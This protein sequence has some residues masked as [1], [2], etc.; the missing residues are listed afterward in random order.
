[1]SLTSKQVMSLNA[2][3]K[4]LSDST[5]NEQ[6]PKLSSTDITTRFPI[7]LYKV[8]AYFT[9][10]ELIDVIN[11]P[12]LLEG[13]TAQPNVT[14]L[15]E[16]LNPSTAKATIARSIRAHN[17]IIQSLEDA[18][19]NLII[20][21][22][23]GHAYEALKRLT[24][25]YGLTNSTTHA[26]TLIERLQNITKQ[27]SESMTE[28][29]TR[30]ERM[31]NDIQAVDPSSAPNIWYKSIV[32]KGLRHL[33]DY[34]SISLVVTQLD[35]NN[36]WTREAFH[37]YLITQDERNKYLNNASSSSSSSS[38]S[39][40]SSDND[41][42]PAKSLS[43]HTNNNTNNKKYHHPS[44]KYKHRNNNHRNNQSSNNRSSQSSSSSSSRPK[45]CSY[46]HKDGHWV[47]ECRQN[48]H[49]DD[50]CYKCHRQGHRQVDCRSGKRQRDN[51]SNSKS[52][53]THQDNNSNNKR[54]KIDDT[55][56]GYTSFV[57]MSYTRSSS[58]SRSSAYRAS[59]STSSSTWIA[60]SAATHHFTGNI[61]LL[62]NITKLSKPRTTDTANGIATCN[63]IGDIHLI[64]NN[65]RLTLR[66]VMYIPSF[67]VNLISVR[68]LT[69]TN[70]EF[71]A[72]STHA[73][74]TKDNKTL[75]TFHLIDNLYQVNATL[76]TSS[77]RH[78]PIHRAAT[79]PPSEEISETYTTVYGSDSMNVEGSTSTISTTPSSSSSSSN[80]PVIQLPNNVKVIADQI[81]DLHIRHGHINY[82]RLMKMIQEQYNH[83]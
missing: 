28:Y 39:P 77:Y 54:N 17:L 49:K 7:W 58:S 71:K 12:V 74:I 8:Q 9:A 20:T 79:R 26:L 65:K 41:N 51:T 45:R 4:V 22:K 18:Q 31:F 19:L 80:S 57:V 60:D 76:H 34:K 59:S 42:K 2:V 35:A 47:T 46:C 67:T 13:E 64:I 30:V 72:T 78:S 43:T 16:S 50:T 24:Q 55:N 38:S 63:T 11:H 36:E 10:K 23:L 82:N 83:H 68:S 3:K 37:Q 48:P 15:P 27:S 73:Y 40:S 56:D 25:T 66:E 44:S 53:Y 69:A 1:M 32:L 5:H 61:N 62:T 21:I 6:L 52:H 75:F 29:L 33:P 81:Y 14:Y 70:C